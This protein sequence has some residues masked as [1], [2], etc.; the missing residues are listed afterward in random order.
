M[1]LYGTRGCVVFLRFNPRSP[2]EI[3]VLD[4]FDALEK[5]LAQCVFVPPEF[6]HDDVA[7]LLRWHSDQSYYCVS[8][9][10][11]DAAVAILTHLDAGM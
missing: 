5:L 2:N 6:Q 8:F 9:C 4:R 1:P 11:W 3:Q 7:Q 10:D